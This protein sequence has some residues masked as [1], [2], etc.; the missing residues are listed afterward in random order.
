MQLFGV[1]KNKV[2]WT[3]DDVLN[4]PWETTFT[5]FMTVLPSGEE[6]V[7]L[8]TQV[9]HFLTILAPFY[10]TGIPKLFILCK[11]FVK[12]NFRLWML[13]NDVFERHQ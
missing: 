10:E 1:V 12:K 13:D 6:D 3:C 2:K 8:L 4:L 7:V 9:L 11:L 5:R